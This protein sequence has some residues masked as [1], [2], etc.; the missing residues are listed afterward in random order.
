MALALGASGGFFLGL[1][2]MLGLE[3]TDG[4]IRDAAA[5]ARA[6]G[7]P[8][9]A[10][11]P[12]TNAADAFRQLRAVLSPEDGSESARTILYASAR[13]GEGRSF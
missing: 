3:L 11:I 10:R 13:A 9:L 4:R 1:V 7:V 12:A 8:L 5:A 6:A 2:L